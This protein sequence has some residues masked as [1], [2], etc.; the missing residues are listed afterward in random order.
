MNT[1]HLT[2]LLDEG[3]AALTT[4]SGALATQQ[5]RL[6]CSGVARLTSAQLDALFAAIPADWDVAD[7]HTVI[8]ADTLSDTL[9]NQIVACVDERLGRTA[10]PA[11]EQPRTAVDLRRILEEALINDLR[12]PCD[13]PE[14]IVDER[15]VRGRYVAGLLAPKGQS[16]IP[17]ISDDSDPHDRA[18]EDG[19]TDAPPSK[20]ASTMLPSLIGMTF[21][22]SPFSPRALDRGLSALLASLIRL[23]EPAFN[24][25]DGAGHVTEQHPIVQATLDQIAARAGHVT[26]TAS[27]TL[28]QQALTQRMDTWQKNVAATIGATLGYKAHKDG[29]TV[30]LLRTPGGADWHLFACLNSLRDVEPTVNLVLDDAGMDDHAGQTW[31]FDSQIGIAQ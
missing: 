15:N 16:A 21:S 31:T 28:V 23:R 1:L 26:S 8:A 24:P 5:A 27:A 6:D 29:T 19:T 25:N 10:A 3:P 12:G 7:L 20:A 18:S 9:A 13:G 22:V 14:E 4:A 17:E 30:G 11:A 2:R